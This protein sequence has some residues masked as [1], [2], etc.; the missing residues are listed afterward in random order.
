MGTSLSIHVQ[1]QT[2]SIS[3]NGLSWHGEK[4]WNLL[5]K[6]LKEPHFEKNELDILKKQF[7]KNK[8][9]S[10]DS[11]SSTARYFWKTRLFKNS[12][13]VNT[14]T[15]DS[16]SKITQTDIQNFYNEHYRQNRPL[17]SVVGQ[18]KKTLKN[19][20]ISFAEECFS[21]SKSK[22]HQLSIIP[23]PARFILL[24]K[25]DLVQ[26]Q[27]VM[28]YPISAFPVQNPKQYLATCL[29]NLALGGG[30]MNSRFFVN[31]RERKGLTY[32]TFSE[33]G[34]GKK[35][36]LFMI[37]GSTKT[38]STIE[39]LKEI[40]KTLKN[41]RDKGIFP[42]ELNRSKQTAKSHYLNQIETPEG[43]LDQIVYYNYYLGVNSDFYKNYLDIIN[44]ISIDEVNQAIQ[45]L[46]LSK[47]LN[48]TIYGHPSLKQQLEEWTIENLPPFETIS[49]K[50]H[51]KN[52]LSY[53]P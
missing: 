22:S 49:F 51:F 3:L 48:L 30:N 34:F 8:L 45:Q 18:F 17:I 12:L 26:T 2:T 10:L 38:L 31:L 29:A 25:E 1:N 40:F 7:I 42:E 52:E 24:T 46:I 28:G 44:D 21:Q 47:K 20:I 5:A 14:G 36:G 50:D 43:N 32:S 27:I 19:R 11:P 15:V 53:R 35:Y 23:Q 39:F 33:A 6:I 41:F 9:T 37:S 13:S 4:L 16:F